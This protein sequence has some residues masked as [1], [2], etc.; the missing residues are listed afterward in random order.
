MEKQEEKLSNESRS[1]SKDD[2]V[3]KESIH[4]SDKDHDD[5]GVGD[6]GR[7]QLYGDSKQGK[8]KPF[9]I[10]LH[11]SREYFDY[12]SKDD[13]KVFEELKKFNAVAEFTRNLVGIGEAHPAKVIKIFDDDEDKKWASAYNLFDNYA[14]FNDDVKRKEE[15]EIKLVLV[16]PDGKLFSFSK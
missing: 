1:R 14:K 15:K 12:L 10:M 5:S 7:D 4:Q 3:S 11:P 8:K 6:F 13:D 16:I 2:S 9:E